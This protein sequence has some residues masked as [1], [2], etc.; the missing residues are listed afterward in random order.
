MTDPVATFL[1]RQPVMILD[2]GLATEL[3]RRGADLDDPLWSARQL[4]DDPE[5]VRQVHRAYLDAGADCIVSAS[6]Q[7]TYEGFAGRGLDREATAALLRRSVELAMA[8][9]D[10]LWN[11]LAAPGDRQRPLVAASIGPYGAFLADGS[12]YR[13]DYGLEVEDLA[14]FHRRRLEVLQSSGA[15]LLAVETIPSFPEALALA[16]LLEETSGNAGPGGTASVSWMSFSCRDRRS[17]WDGTPLRRAIE[18]IEGVP[19]IVALGVN[20]TAPELIVG[21][22]REAAAA[23]DKPLVAYPNSGE[24]YDV[25]TRSWMTAARPFDW[26]AGCQSWYEAGARLIGGCCRSRPADIA[27]MRETLL[28]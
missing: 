3:E 22:L 2:G 18:E 11:G 20:C 10:E 12:E 21:L 9:R 28:A 13:G 16:G 27:A 17:L 14:R 19:R 7:A 8:A 5:L 15:D 26:R 23:T 4:L 6:Y 24:G 1:S 25:A